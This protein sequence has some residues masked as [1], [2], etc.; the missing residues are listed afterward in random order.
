VRVGGGYRLEFGHPNSEQPTAFFGKYRRVTPDSRLVGT[1]EE[2]DDGA[3]TSVT[4]EGQGDRTILVLHELYP[5]KEALDSSMVGMDAGAVQA[6][7]QASRHPGY[8]YIHL[9]EMT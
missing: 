1:N 3:V 5:T 7:G 2:G 4:L 9:A 6:A 8:G